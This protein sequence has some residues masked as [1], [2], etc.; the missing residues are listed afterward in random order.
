MTDFHTTHVG[1]LPRPQAMMTKI[2]RKQEI[3]STDLRRYLIEL[4]EK[5][6]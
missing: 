5:Q 3:T 6:L 4:V 2:L 1:S